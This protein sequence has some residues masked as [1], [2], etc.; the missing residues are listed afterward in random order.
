MTPYIFKL[1]NG[2]LGIRH[3]A[4]S[5]NLNDGELQGP[6]KT[7][8]IYNVPPGSNWEYWIKQELAKYEHDLQGPGNAPAPIPVPG[9]PVPLN[10][11]FQ[12]TGII[13][14]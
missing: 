10:L 8:T 9:P 6:Y 7:E 1:S 11:V 4:G 2:D 5:R 14:P 13:A 12:G 3:E